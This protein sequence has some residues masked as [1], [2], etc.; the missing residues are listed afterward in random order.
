MGSAHGGTGLEVVEMARE[1]TLIQRAVDLILYPG[2]STHGVPNQ[3][4]DLPGHYLPA[5]VGMHEGNG[6]YQWD[7][8]ERLC[9]E[10]SRDKL[11]NEDE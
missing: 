7:L 3:L 9:W 8:W 4:L 2:H 1:D 10:D 5:P 6:E 11:V